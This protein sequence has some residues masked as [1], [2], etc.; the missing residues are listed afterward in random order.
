[1]PVAPYTNDVGEYISDRTL[2]AYAWRDQITPNMN[3]ELRFGYQV[4]PGWFDSGQNPS[5]FPSIKTPQGATYYDPGVP[6]L[7]TDPFQ[8]YGPSKTNA[9]LK[10]LNETLS[11]LHGNHSFTFGGSFTNV[12]VIDDSSGQT[13]ASVDTGM[14]DEDPAL[15]AAVGTTSVWSSGGELPGISSSDL[16]T[17]E[18]LWST[19]D[20]RVTSFS[21]SQNVDPV[22]RAYSPQ[23]NSFENVSMNELGLFFTDDW[24]MSS[25]LTF[26]YGLRWEYESP[27]KDN[28]NEYYAAT[29]NAYGISGYGNL[30][31]PGASSGAVPSYALPTGSLYNS[32][33]KGFAP[34]VGLAWTPQISSGWLGS[35]LGG[36]GR[37][38]FRAGY[39]IAYDREGMSTYTGAGPFRNPGQSNSLF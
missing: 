23:S 13:V 29:G 30:F 37:S 7:M 10:Q 22:K 21:Q 5:V 28:L 27:V 19:L 24:R 16:G 18:N 38:V 3:N 11:W 25:N 20:G 26:N 34:S 39:S 32:Y 36:S 14:S 9:P 17:A 4:V 15:A 8:G 1:F 33:K 35:L 2:M 31:Q 12:A 6:S